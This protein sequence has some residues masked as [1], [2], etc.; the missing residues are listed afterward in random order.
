MKKNNTRGIVTNM[1][2]GGPGMGM[3]F[4]LS[5]KSVSNLEDAISYELSDISNEITEAVREY[6]DINPINDKIASSYLKS[7]GY[8]INRQTVAR[9]RNKLG[10]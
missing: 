9:V 8:N 10:F 6:Y 7:N 3:N 2:M 5:P 1:S 4:R